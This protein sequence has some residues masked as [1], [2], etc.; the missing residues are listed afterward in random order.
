MKSLKRIM[1]EF[2]IYGKQ[3]KPDLPLLKDP[4]PPARTKGVRVRASKYMPHQ[5][6]QEVARRMEMEVI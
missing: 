1:R 4:T 6:K 3:G 5:G 2:R